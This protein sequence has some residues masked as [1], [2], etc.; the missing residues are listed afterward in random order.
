MKAVR[1]LL[2]TLIS[3]IFIFGSVLSVQ[4]EMERREYSKTNRELIIEGKRLSAIN[5]ELIRQ[6]KEYIMEIQE[7]LC[8]VYDNR[9]RFC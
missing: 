7:L 5:R 4:K 8:K 3:S 6:N 9:P 1:L 2:I